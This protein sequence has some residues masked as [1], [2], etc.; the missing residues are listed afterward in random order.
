LRKLSFLQCA[1]LKVLPRARHT[2]CCGGKSLTLALVMIASMQLLPERLLASDLKLVLGPRVRVS[3]PGVGFHGL[4]DLA[5]DRLASA[6][7]MICGYRYS[8][9]QNSTIGYVYLSQDQGESWRE[10]LKDDS[11][12]WVTEDSCASGAGRASFMG[13]SQLLEFEKVVPGIP[14]DEA[15]DIHLYSSFDGGQSWS[16]LSRRGWVDSSA[17][18]I[19]SSNGLYRGRIYLFG[20]NQVDDPSGS[21]S[22]PLLITSD[23]GKKL[24]GPVRP[25]E[26][27]GFSYRGAYANAARVLP[28]GDV[29]ALFMARRRATQTDASQPAETHVELFATRNGGETME[30]IADLGPIEPCTGAMPSFDVNPQTGAMY[31]VWGS[32]EHGNCRLNVT[33]TVDEGRTWAPPNGVS[34]TKDG[35]A[36]AI[37]VNDKGIVALFWTDRTESHCWRFSASSDGGQNFSPPIDVSRCVPTS[38]QADLSHSAYAT[39]YVHTNNH[40]EGWDVALDAI[41]FSVVVSSDGMI[42][43]RVG[44][45][46][47]STGTFR[48]VWPEATDEA[49]ALWS[50]TVKVE[51]AAHQEDRGANTT[52]VSHDLALEFRNSDYDADSGVYAVDVTAVNR[53]KEILNG[54]ITLIVE[55]AYSRFFQ[56]V[57]SIGSDQ[58][59]NR[60]G[61]NW[62]LWPLG[63][64]KLL[65]P[66]QQTINRRLS[67]R[68]QQP[69]SSQIVVGDLLSVK[70]RALSPQ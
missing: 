43:W 45:A 13:E 63:G 21:F 57:A 2:C 34:V 8:R 44:L 60:S 31:V 54:P 36:P 55:S 26:P 14:L 3:P 33:Y 16:M 39:S 28:N 70:M 27:V 22:M 7:L 67:F 66:G 41:G 1:S 65:Y 52:D 59:T 19:D 62:M 64:Q 12:M 24:Y 32:M 11:S 61:A 58:L 30:E 17:T 69:V 42:P 40:K 20:A 18:A 37:A 15:G 49:G 48:A 50:T 25:P 35:Y 38:M 47:D 10:V 9:T 46:A 23:D 29:V 51:G 4:V 5:I 56:S 6:D 68:L 53:G